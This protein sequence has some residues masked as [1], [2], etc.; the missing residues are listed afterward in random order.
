MPPRYNIPTL[1]ALLVI[2]CSVEGPEQ[3]VRP[4]E[5]S[6][7][8]AGEGYLGAESCK[9]CHQEEYD[10]WSHSAHA[11]A[12]TEATP[13]FVRGDFVTDTTHTYDGVSY[14][15]FRRDESFYIRAP[16]RGGSPED[17]L[18]HYTLGTTI[19]SLLLY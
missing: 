5:D 4:E 12:M 18:V 6:R 2:A 16:T 14:T 13:E 1:F 19:F 8:I 17:F 11:R 3:T 7:A 9:E 15:M 10:L